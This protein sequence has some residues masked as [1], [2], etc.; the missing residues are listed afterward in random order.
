MHM[1]TAELTGIGRFRIT[2]KPVPSIRTGTEVLIKVERAGICGSDIQY[3]T[4]G[5]IGDARVEYPFTVG[6]ECAGS[7]VEAGKAV[8]R[9]NTGDRV[10]VDPT[11]SCGQCDQC[12]MGR[13][14]TCRNILFLGSP[15]ELSGCMSEYIV[16]PESC[17]FPIKDSMTMEQAVIAEPLAIGIYSVKSAGMDPGAKAAVLGAG[18]IGLSVLLAARTA[19][20]GKLYVSEK[21]PYRLE[22]ARAAG[23]DWVGNPDL[24]DVPALINGREKDQL[25]VV[26]ECCGKQE[27]LDQGVDLLKPG[28]RLVIVGIP[29]ID[30]VS[31]SIHRLRRKEIS[32]VNVRRQFG[33]TQDAIDFIT[34]RGTEVDFMTTHTFP[35]EWIERGF[36]LVSEYG[37]GVIKAMIA[38]KGKTEG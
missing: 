5:G 33:C 25:D 15:G 4:S 1:K 35:L 36:R 23:A 37:D 3:Y 11:V 22:A 31:F 9:V 18:P 34:A 17:C 10:A 30:R 7:V 26:F 38:P 24:E 8:S 27:A 14:H 2:E 12:R 19:G 29:K 13:V 16:M 32:V 20:A 6:H 28:G 21:L